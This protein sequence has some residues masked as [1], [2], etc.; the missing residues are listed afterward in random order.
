MKRVFFFTTDIT[1]WVSLPGGTVWRG[2]GADGSSHGTY[3][4]QSKTDG[5][6]VA[7]GAAL[8]ELL[9]QRVA[10][11][12]QQGPALLGRHPPR[13]RLQDGDGGGGGNAAG[14]WSGACGRR[15]AGEEG[16]MREAKTTRH[17]SEPCV[18]CQL[19]DQALTLNT[20]GSKC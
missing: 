16:T 6:D 2:S 1:E 12:V 18:P 15:R 5:G 19:K 7:A 13:S 20:N 14:Q 17:S 9:R 10:E 4:R 3:V 8:R 11:H